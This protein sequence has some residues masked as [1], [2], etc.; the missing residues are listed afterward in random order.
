MFIPEKAIICAPTSEDAGLLFQF[1]GTNGYRFGGD[2]PTTC[3][4]GWTS[5]G[6]DTCYN[7]EPDKR[8]CY[9]Y[10]DYYKEEAANFDAGD[11]NEYTARYMPEDPNLRFISVADFITLCINASEVQELE[12]EN[13]ES[14]L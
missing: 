8:I 7:L 2:D 13:L 9:C 10:R 1:L 12:I 11:M 14:V 5:Y 4:H 6:V 3:D